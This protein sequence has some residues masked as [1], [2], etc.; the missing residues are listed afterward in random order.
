M[1][2]Q[3]VSIQL[4]YLNREFVVLNARLARVLMALDD[5]QK[6]NN[7]VQLAIDELKLALIDHIEGPM[8]L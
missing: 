5:Q 4:Q 2:Q 7:L 8:H 1:E 6:G 3:P